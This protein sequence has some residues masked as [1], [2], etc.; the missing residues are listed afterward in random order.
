MALSLARGCGARAPA[1]PV[2]S[3]C[4]T[5]AGTRASAAHRR[6]PGRVA[7][8]SSCARRRTSTL[9]SRILRTSSKRLR[10]SP[11]QWPMSRRP[12]ARC[13]SPSG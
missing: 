8:V 5:R 2:Q 4:P 9:C 11:S 10:T 3:A 7:Q 1:R 6:G 13:S 12:S